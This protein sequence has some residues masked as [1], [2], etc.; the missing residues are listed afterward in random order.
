MPL[1]IH[2]ET[3]HE[4]RVDRIAVVGPGI[5]GMPM[6][7]LLARARI[8]IGGDDPAKVVVVQRPSKTSGWKV[9]AINSGTSPIGGVEPGLDEIVAEAVAAGTLSATSD[10]SGIRDA[11]VVLICVQTDKDGFAPDYGPLMSALDGVCAALRERPAGNVPL[12]I[13]EST[14]A[15]SSMTTLVRERFQA[16]GLVEGRDV[17][18]GNSP[19]CV[20]PGRLV[21]RVEL[22]SKLAGDSIR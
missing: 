3:D 6:A 11:D 13:F 4:W 16:A 8:R 22:Q 5:V 2:N 21:D 19:N 12:I 20:M 17:L 9:D 15:P 1:N 18:L 7:A 10:P 14:L